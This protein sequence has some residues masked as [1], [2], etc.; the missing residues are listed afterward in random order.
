MRHGFLLLGLAILIFLP[1]IFSA[2]FLRHREIEELLTAMKSV[3]VGDPP[4]VFEVR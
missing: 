1:A 3:L 2:P 4:P